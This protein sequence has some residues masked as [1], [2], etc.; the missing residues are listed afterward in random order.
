MASLKARH[1]FWRYDFRAKA[2]L[3]TKDNINELI[4]SEGFTGEIGLRI[5][6]LIVICEYNVILGDLF[7]LTV[8]YDPA[9]QRSRAHHSLLYGGY[10]GA[11]VLV[12]PLYRSEWLSQMGAA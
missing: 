9:F 10:S 12:G 5:S 8:A 2:A 4:R 7:A 3:I 11:V 1:L 6:P